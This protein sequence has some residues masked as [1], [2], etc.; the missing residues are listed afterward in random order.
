MKTVQFP[1]VKK[2]FL[3]VIG[4]AIISIA[5]GLG[6]G[7]FILWPLLGAKYGFGILWGALVGITFQVFLILEIQ[8]YTV[9][10]GNDII[11]GFASI[12]KYLPFWV[13][14]STILGFGWPGWAATG[15]TLIVEGF[16]FGDH[17]TIA[18]LIITLSAGILLAG[19]NTY[20]IIEVSQKIFLPLSFLVVTIIFALLFDLEVFK[21]MMMGLI[22][23][24]EGYTF[25]P[26]G[27]DLAIFLGAFAYAGSGGNLLLLNSFYAIEEKVGIDRSKS[28]LPINFK[29]S[30][31]KQS[32][33]NFKKLRLFQLVEGIGVFWLLGL[34]TICMLVYISVVLTADASVEGFEF[35]LIEKEQIA[36]E[37]NDL[38]AGAFLITG[39]INLSSVQLGV[40]DLAGRIFQ[41]S[42]KSMGLFEDLSAKKIYRATVFTMYA[43]GLT[44]LSFGFDQPEFLI[45]TGAVFNALS[46]GVIAICTLIL[47]N[48]I[49]QKTFSP[50]A[51]AKTALALA[52]TTYILLFVLSF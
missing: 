34:S 38:L 51:I 35:L 24:G 27:I 30:E 11:K 52:F 3:E 37:F 19:K 10:S 36:L 47:V 13:I 8:R 6:S 40:Y 42:F 48:R 4:P 17:R 2:S 7:E 31:S 15:S 29:L 45:I 18:I 25:L 5:L 28:Q 33:N 22:G 43:I 21:E 46:M 23:Q 26:E 9:T 14:F 16:G 49:S 1:K 50:G 20:R 39:V 12:S 41:Y 32:T 44:I